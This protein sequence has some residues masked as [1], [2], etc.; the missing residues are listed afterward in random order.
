MALF[1]GLSWAERIRRLGFPTASPLY[2]TYLDVFRR[3][4]MAANHPAAQRPLI[5]MPVYGLILHFEASLPE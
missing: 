3:D 4:E 5:S 1:S 2:E